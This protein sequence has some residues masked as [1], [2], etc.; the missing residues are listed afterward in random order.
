MSTQQL[1]AA[2]IDITLDTT[3]L[4]LGIERA[5]SRMADMSGATQAEYGKM[6]KAERARIDTLKRQ[7][8]MLGLTRQEQI[9]YNITQRTSGKVQEDLLRT[10]SK[11]TA[12]LQRNG[13][14][15]GAAAIQFNKYGLSAKQTQAAL[16]QVPAQVTDIFVS[17]QGGQNPLTVLLQQ[18]GQLKDVFGGVRPA[19]AAL[20]NQLIG[21]VTPMNV[22]LAIGAGL[23]VAFLKGDS[24]VSNYGKS[25]ALLGDR[26][27]VTTGDLQTMAQVISSPDVT[28]GAA[29]EALNAVVTS[30]KFAAEQ[31]AI[32]AEAAVQM[33][34]A[35]GQ[36]VDEVIGKFAELA[37]DPVN[38]V[39]KLNEEQ[40]FLTIAIYD[41]IKALQ[42]QGD[43][44]GAATLAMQAYADAVEERT[45][46]VQESLGYLE[47]AWKSVAN[48]AKQAWDAML[49][50]GRPDT[51][52][53][54]VQGIT[55]EIKALETS[56]LSFLQFGLVGSEQ[57]AEQIRQ[58]RAE[59]QKIL[60][61]DINQNRE[62]LIESTTRQIN[63]YA[64]AQD[65][66]IAGTKSADEKRAAEITRSRAEANALIAKAENLGMKEEAERLRKNQ[67]AYEKGLEAQGQKR[68]K[69]T[70]SLDRAETRA[71][72]QD[73]KDALVERQAAIQADTRILQ[74]E[75]SA[76]LVS[77]TE[78][79]AQ[80][81]SLME[82]MAQ[83]EE[84]SLVG[85]IGY[86][87]SRNVA[88]KE[89]IDV[90]RQLGQLEAQLAKTRAKN[91]ADSK[92]LSI[93]EQAYAKQ[94]ENSMLDFEE[95]LDLGTQAMRDQVD[96][97]IQAIGMGQRQF[98]IQQ[99]INA[100]LA[101]AA[102]RERELAKARRDGQITP[103]EYARQSAASARAA[104]ERV[105]VEQDAYARIN[106]AQQDWRAGMRAGLEDWVATASD[107]SG[108]VRD[109]TVN[110]LDRVTDAFVEAALTG[111]FQ[112][113][114]MLADILTEITKFLAKQ[115]VLELVKLGT[116][117]FMSYMGN[118]SSG[119]I[120]NSNF[121]GPQ[122][123]GGAFPRLSLG[124]HTNTV[125]DQPTPFYFAKGAS[126]GVMGEAG[127]EA[128]MPLKRG[129]DGSLGV[130]MYEGGGAGNVAITM[131]FNITGD[132][133]QA[134][135]TT[136]G[137]E[138]AAYRDFAKRMQQIAQDEV[139]RAMRPGGM[140]W[141]AGVGA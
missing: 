21:L 79:F 25:I 76:K 24:E 54:R 87:Q 63:D 73:F 75:Y 133:A 105:L 53:E 84:E 40:S 46:D 62:D 58:R 29:A 32:V 89:A 9:A 6:N 98:E 91:A 126:F 90:E 14:A 125:V 111:K 113:R 3:E 13:Q 112:W 27:R 134:S 95:A 17:L 38:A 99:R 81:R 41:Q 55:D 52:N 136:T 16:R 132:D 97:Q 120:N 31:Y 80:S 26:A 85:Q 116:S 123:L 82:Q 33:S 104:E 56:N 20:A 115:A 108:Q 23:G 57:R 119:A 139:M 103:A 106:A 92:V 130:K 59:L 88:G 69:S 140:L 67:A 100:I 141:K 78:Y 121:I 28:Q 137:E 65:R 70:A 12:E 117:M 8:D 4:E 127:A 30:G 124:A 128:I 72:L 39:A 18:G 45:G 36:S 135:T 5:K 35:T 77:Q 107:V 102:D 74:A 71:G 49:D 1:G 138:A 131:Q 110:A 114:A 50:L 22:L 47:S 96:S 64:V 122:A 83:A 101:E 48:V 93:Q 51:L 66:L 60:R 68:G 42:A 10:L 15:A 19:V 44:I 2:R 118:S 86:L 11:N 94:R 129:P 7:V 61:D 109:L 37:K 43:T 34:R